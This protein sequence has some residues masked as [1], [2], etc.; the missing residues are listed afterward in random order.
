MHV[1]VLGP[2]EVRL[3]DGPV[4]LGGP[5]ERAVLEMLALRAGQPVPTESLW[6]GLW[7][8]SA[9]PSAAKVLQG[10]I[11]HLR[12]VLPP[13]AIATEGSGY[14]LQLDRA[15]VDASGFE[16]RLQ[17]AGRQQGAGNLTEAAGPSAGLSLW[18]GQP[19]PDLTEHSW[20]TA[21]VARLEELRRQAEDDL[22]EV[23]LALGEHN[24]LVGDLEA[25]VASEPVRER[26]WAQLM[27]ALYRA[28]RQADALRAYARLRT[29]LAEELGIGPSA[30]LVALERSVLEQSSDLDYRPFLGLLPASPSTAQGALRGTVPVPADAFV[31]R[32]GELA[33][34]ADLVAKRR[35]V[36]LAG[37][38]GCG[39]TRLAIEVATMLFNSFAGG[40]HF[41]ALAP[42]GDPTLVPGAVADALGV[43]PESARPLTQ[44]ISEFVGHLETLVVVDNCEHVVEA[45]AVL[46]DELLQ[47][48]PGL[49]VLATSRDPLRIAGEAVWRVA[50]LDLPPP[51]AGA[52]TARRSSAV[53]LFVDRALAARPGFVWT[54]R[55]SPLSPKSAGAWTGYR[56]PLSWQR[57]GWAWS[58]WPTSKTGSMTASPC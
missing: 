36:M 37:P 22:A 31:G 23:R 15:A 16:E 48:A 29:A 33:E 1:A 53:E 24:R 44:V 47:G 18:R 2:L 58:T 30:E 27:L 17:E 54:I 14:V 10:H 55:P 21:A 28:G 51:G 52:E 38:A 11:S 13:G 19:C 40:A 35:L 20:A 3:A 50:P 4:A 49:R 56:W 34:V 41:A 46:V 26:R 43:R 9:P 12:H 8:D 42:V 57:H 32:A 45:A 7:G 5:K 25:A 6:S 39:K